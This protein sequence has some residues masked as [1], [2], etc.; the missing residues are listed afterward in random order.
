MDKTADYYYTDMMYASLTLA[1]Q[2]SFFCTC[3]ICT[4]H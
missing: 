2:P 1:I 3:C 4:T